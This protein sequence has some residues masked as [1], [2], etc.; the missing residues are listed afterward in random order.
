MLDELKSSYHYLNVSSRSGAKPTNDT[1]EAVVRMLK[2]RVSERQAKIRQQ[3]QD[4]IKERNQLVGAQGEVKSKRGTSTK[5]LGVSYETSKCSSHRS[6][7]V[8]GSTAYDKFKELDVFERLS[9]DARRKQSTSKEGSM[10]RSNAG[11]FLK[12]DNGPRI[13]DRL[14]KFKKEHQNWVTKQRFLKKSKEL[15]T[16][17]VTKRPSIQ[18]F[19]S[20]L[21][22]PL[23]LVLSYINKI[24]TYIKL[25]NQSKNS[26]QNQRALKKLK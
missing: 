20:H 21:E 16:Q 7:K 14:L 22:R 13:E 8:K 3:V 25:K 6:P 19:K 12:A 23:N 11:S 1:P 4:A 9:I 10:T 18:P 15:N 2:K 24:S 17:S 5:K 26:L